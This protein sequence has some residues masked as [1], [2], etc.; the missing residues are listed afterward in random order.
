MRKLIIIVVAL[1]SVTAVSAQEELPSDK[2]RPLSSEYKQV[3]GFIIDMGLFRMPE[4]PRFKPEEMLIDVTKDYSIIFQMDPSWT[5]SKA[6]ISDSYYSAYSPGL[7]GG[8]T[9]DMLV[10]TFRLNDK[11][12]ISLFGQYR[13]DGTKIH[14]TSAYP[15]EKNMFR[16]GFELKFNK[17]FGIRMEVNRGNNYMFPY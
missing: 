14:N 13:M 11:M 10:G 3:G 8:G 4:M 7:L 5:V 16:G 2:T 9:Q 15:W 6:T 1:L 12:Q 17:S